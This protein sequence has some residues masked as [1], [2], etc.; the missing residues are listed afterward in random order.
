MFK[1]QA[2][3]SKFSAA[4]GSITSSDDDFCLFK[5]QT[6]LT[7]TSEELEES[8]S[9]ILD[10]SQI[11]AVIKAVEASKTKGADAAR[12]SKLWMINEELAQGALDQNRQLV[13]HSSD[14][15]LSRQISTNDRMLRYRRIQSVLFTDT[16]FAQPKAK[17]S[18]GYT[19]CQ[20]F[21]SDKGFV[22]VY[23]M[24]SQ[25]EFQSALHW[26]CKQVGVPVD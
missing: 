11:N 24:K 22:V 17:S 7:L 12:L 26:F 5:G 25:T 19:C 14:N 1:Q 6:T 16:M 2:E 20:V 4:I 15:I 18:R 21:V 3:E 8:L 10:D 13:R 9:S 23:P